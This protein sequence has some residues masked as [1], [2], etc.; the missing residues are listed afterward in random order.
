MK[1]TY[2]TILRGTAMI[3]VLIVGIAALD[4]WFALPVPA[5]PTYEE[6]AGATFCQALAKSTQRVSF[7][8]LI[9]GWIAVLAS[10]LLAVAGSILGSAST[11][12][13]NPTPWQRIKSQRGLVC[14]T[15]AVILGSGGWHLL[16]RSNDSTLAAR[17]ATLAVASSA[18]A[19]GDLAAYK[20]CAEAKGL[21][22]DGR[23]Q[24][25]ELKALATRLSRE[26]E[27]EALAPQQEP[28]P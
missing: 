6:G 27:D 14:T 2:K 19:G 16:S 18:D 20:S 13:E 15:L 10:S 3:V 7:W 8:L 22:L 4:L 26:N 21:W 17:A 11:E 1:L 5:P 23:A 25:D 24:Q 28:V 9:P 12:G